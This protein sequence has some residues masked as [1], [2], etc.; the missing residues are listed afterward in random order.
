MVVGNYI[1]LL[2]QP[3]SVIKLKSCT[4]AIMTLLIVTVS[5]CHKWRKRCS[6]IIITIPKNLL[7][8]KKKIIRSSFVKKIK[9]ISNF[10]CAVTETRGYFSLRFITTFYSINEVHETK[11]L[12]KIRQFTFYRMTLTWERDW[13][14][15]D[16]ND[17]VKSPLVYSL[18]KTFVI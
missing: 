17:S 5:R 1:Y 8:L 9:G 3:V 18:P 12:K 10:N 6:F 2:V 7:R 16:F 4:V 11:T 13:M 15:C 14:N